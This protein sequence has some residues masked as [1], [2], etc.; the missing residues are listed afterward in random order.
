MHRL[1]IRISVLFLGLCLSVPSVAQESMGWSI[2]GGKPW[3]DRMGPGI[4]FAVGGNDCTG[5]YCDDILDAS[6]IGS[7][8]GTLGAYWRF[9]PNLSAFIDV[10]AGYVNTDHRDVYLM[11]EATSGGNELD[12]RVIKDD[13][14]LLVQATAGAQ[15]HF[16]FT[17]WFEAYL[18]FGVGFAML[19]SKSNL[20][21]VGDFI[22]THKG[23]NFELKIGTDFYLFSRIPT[24]GLGP[25]FRMGF[26]VWPSLCIEYEGSTMSSSCGNPDAQASD[27]ELPAY[28]DTPFLIFLGL[29][30]RY[31]F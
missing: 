7:I 29:S 14:G 9:I 10:H 8:A 18:G 5:N 11:R 31:A 12:Q 30:G 4:T 3:R 6:L 25:L 2:Q 24:F 16:P 28:A 22:K 20:A 27:S 13:F 15:A 17:G 26:T 1:L 23:I 21:G 19:R